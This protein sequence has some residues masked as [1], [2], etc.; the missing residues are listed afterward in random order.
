ME[1]AQKDFKA[2]EHS[3]TFAAILDAADGTPS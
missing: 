3:Q 2:V 1:D